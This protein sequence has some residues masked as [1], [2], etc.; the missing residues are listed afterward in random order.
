MP[1]EKVYEMVP[2]LTFL[3]NKCNEWQDKFNADTKN[4][5]K[6]DLVFFL[7]FLEHLMRVTRICNMKRSN[8]MLV[9][10]GGSGKQSVTKFAT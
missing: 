9:G 4:K 6:F 5:K 8:G 10:V 2:S 7:Y 1:P 3:K